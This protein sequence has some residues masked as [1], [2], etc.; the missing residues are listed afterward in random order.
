M[1]VWSTSCELHALPGV[2]LLLKSLY[3]MHIS[4]L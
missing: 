4:T 3:T 1:R 2:R